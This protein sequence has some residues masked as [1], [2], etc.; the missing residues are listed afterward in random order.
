MIAPARAP[1]PRRTG[2]DLR[3]K[4]L[5]R[6]Q[7]L[8]EKEALNVITPLV[9][10]SSTTTTSSSSSSSSSIP[11]LVSSRL[12]AVLQNVAS[13]RK[14]GCKQLVVV[15]SEHLAYTLHRHLCK[16]GLHVIEIMA[17][18]LATRQQEFLD[19]AAVMRFNA[20]SPATIALLCLTS[21]SS[22]LTETMGE[23]MVEEEEGEKVKSILASVLRVDV[24][25]VAEKVIAPS[26]ITL[27]QNLL[28]TLASPL[29]AST[30][31]VEI[32][33]ETESR[34]NLRI[35][36]GKV[37]NESAAANCIKQ[38]LALSTPKKEKEK[39]LVCEVLDEGNWRLLEKDHCD[40]DFLFP[41][42]EC[43]KMKKSLS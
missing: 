14:E 20:A 37:S 40:R 28:A 23:M 32:L 17:N 42:N 3:Y 27:Y 26:S 11:T 33:S 29:N 31:I 5:T 1:Q 24:V 18:P 36:R 22:S 38:L 13:N 25:V 6:A 10:Q 15:E 39:P 34:L 7:R 43:R 8:A 30:H 4:W 19:T 2:S 21:S 9:S 41:V 35:P 16:Q 12:Q